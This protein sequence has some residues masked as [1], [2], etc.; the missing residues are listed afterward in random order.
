MVGRG[1]AVAVPLALALSSFAVVLAGASDPAPLGAVLEDSRPEMTPLVL[2]TGTEILALDAGERTAVERW[3]RR[4]GRLQLVGDAPLPALRL[5]APEGTPAEPASVW[6]GLGRITVIGDGSAERAPEATSKLDDL[7]VPATELARAG[8]PDAGP[9]RAAAAARL[10][11]YAVLLFA[12]LLV[13]R[14]LPPAWRRAG[15]LSLVLLFSS[16]PLW[17]GRTTASADRWFRVDVVVDADGGPALLWSG[18]VLRAGGRHDV[19]LSPGPGA[20]AL[21]EPDPEAS[22]SVVVSSERPRFELEATLGALYRFG[23]LSDEPLSGHVRVEM[24]ERDGRLSGLARNGLDQS[25]DE[26]WL[27]LPG[28]RPVPLGALPPAGALAIDVALPSPLERS[29]S[30][31]LAADRPLA[32]ARLLD[33]VTRRA[34]GPLLERGLPVLVAWSDEPYGAVGRAS[35]TTLLV[36]TARGGGS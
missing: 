9:A 36:T 15:T 35:G 18:A 29:L 3:L 34:V 12:G 11:I 5:L 2:A 28:R 20:W 8:L 32:H 1:G 19:E 27:L 21:Q 23:W 13:S 33:G 22:R 24:V 26:S 10:A 25:W 31:S 7:L 16:W 17:S 14:R 30:R 6:A 4:G